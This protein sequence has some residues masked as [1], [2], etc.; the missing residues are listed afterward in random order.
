MCAGPSLPSMSEVEARGPRPLERGF[1]VDGRFMMTE[2][3]HRA[4]DAVVPDDVR[5]EARAAKKRARVQAHADH[6]VGTPRAPTL[7]V[8]PS[9]RL[10]EMAIK[11]EREKAR[12]HDDQEVK[13]SLG[14]DDKEVLAL[15]IRF[16]QTCGNKQ[17]KGFVDEYYK[18]SEQWEKFKD[19]HTLPGRLEPWLQGD[20]D[21]TMTNYELCQRRQQ[22]VDRIEKRFIRYLSATE[23]KERA[24]AIRAGRV[25]ISLSPLRPSTRDRRFQEALDWCKEHSP[26]AVERYEEQKL[27]GVTGFAAGRIMYNFRV[28][29]ENLP[30]ASGGSGRSGEG[31]GDARERQPPDGIGVPGR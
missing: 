26:H 5:M 14:I 7:V 18:A 30:R 12:L 11:Y 28:H 24:A 2:R 21:L 27:C 1:F 6:D 4:S 3:A 25:S 17:A 8:E 13:R 29:C 31:A 9:T 15:A 19:T 22:L 20:V 23:G 16:S 10:P